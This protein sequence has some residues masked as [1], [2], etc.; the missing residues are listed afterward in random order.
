MVLE[1]KVSTEKLLTIT[2]L[3]FYIIIIVKYTSEY[4]LN[5]IVS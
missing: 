4:T 1:A 2:Q 3:Y 5:I